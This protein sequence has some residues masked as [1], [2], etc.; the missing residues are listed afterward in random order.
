MN[1]DLRID[2]SIHSTIAKWHH[3]TIAPSRMA[4]S[5]QRGL[6]GFVTQVVGVYQ[7]GKR[8]DGAARISLHVHATPAGMGLAPCGLG[9]GLCRKLNGRVANP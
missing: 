6:S 1:H 4:R 2:P 8:S 7:A 5:L 9:W 3:G